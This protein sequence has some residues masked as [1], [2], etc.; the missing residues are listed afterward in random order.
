ML[1]LIR[2]PIPKEVGTPLGFVGMGLFVLVVLGLLIAKFGRKAIVA[3]VV[4]V[5]V[6]VLALVGIVIMNVRTNDSEKTRKLTEANH[7]IDVLRALGNQSASLQACPPSPGEGFLLGVFDADRVT[8]QPKT[9]YETDH[10]LPIPAQPFVERFYDLD[11]FINTSVFVVPVR[12]TSGEVERAI[13]WFPKNDTRCALT[14]E[15]EN[16]EP[17]TLVRDACQALGMNGCR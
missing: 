16:R 2:I 6:A 1:A 17:I 8:W 12:A 9:P 11:F 15:R 4:V 13:V 3:V 14:L 7:R 5:V 10:R